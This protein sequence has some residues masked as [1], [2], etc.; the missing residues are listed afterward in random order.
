MS[1]ENEDLAAEV[2]IEKADAVVFA[3][4]QADQL[5]QLI[6]GLDE[7]DKIIEEGMAVEVAKI[8]K[9]Y[10]ARLEKNAKRRDKAKKRREQLRRMANELEAER[11]G[12]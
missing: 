4:T 9:D 6:A 11:D 5:T 3:R 1:T 7:A 12:E 10:R 2:V 8:E